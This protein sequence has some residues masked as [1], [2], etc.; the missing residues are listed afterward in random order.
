MV[1]AV[2]FVELEGG[3]D[4]D[5]NQRACCCPDLCAMVGGYAH[6]MCVRGWSL[7]ASNHHLSQGSKL[8]THPPT[9]HCP[10]SGVVHLEA[11]QRDVP[12]RRYLAVELHT[13]AEV[14]EI[15]CHNNVAL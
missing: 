6:V 3:G 9:H 5:V 15:G 12:H 14:S 10:V 4:S 11:L 2:D 8:H 7:E 1:A 13:I